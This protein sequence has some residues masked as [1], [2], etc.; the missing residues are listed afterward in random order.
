MAMVEN[1]VY[2]SDQC[3]F[4]TR[5][6]ATQRNKHESFVVLQILVGLYNLVEPGNIDILF[7]S[8]QAEPCPRIDMY[9]DEDEDFLFIGSREPC[10]VIA[11]PFHML[12]TYRT[13]V[14]DL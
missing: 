3:W 1:M 6:A 4:L 8:R 9:K 13:A 7:L 12:R 5:E 10:A 2:L 11:G 14:V